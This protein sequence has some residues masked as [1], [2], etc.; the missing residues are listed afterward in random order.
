MF[1]LLSLGFTLSLDNFRTSIVLG[2]LKPTWPRSVKTS[3]IFGLWD[4]IAPAVG[5]FVGHYLS[6]KIDSTADTIAAIALGAYGLFVVV[7]ALRTPDHA[8]PDMRWATRG[9]P[10]PLSIDNVAAGAS[11]GLLGYSPWLAPLVFGLIT[12]AMSVAGHQIG[13]TAAHFIPRIRTDLLTG[14]AFVA[15]AA[16][17]GRGAIS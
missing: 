9:L 8:D 16:F 12:F 2:G 1:A 14:I 5:I 7:R 10:L 11:L 15:M 13:R 17:V 6:Q 4:G 3:A